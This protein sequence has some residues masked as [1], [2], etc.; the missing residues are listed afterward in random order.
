MLIDIGAGTTGM[1]VYEEG[2]LIGI[3]VFPVGAS[4]ITN[5]LAI[6]LKIPVAHAESIKLGAGYALQ[7]E[8]GAREFVEL[9]AFIPDAKGVLSRKLVAGVIEARLAEILEF[10]HTELKLLGKEGQLPGGAVV[11]GGGAKLPGITELMTREL[12]LSS[13]VGLPLSDG[14]RAEGREVEEALADPE[15]ST[16]IGLALWGFDK[17]RKE[18]KGILGTGSIRRFFKNLLP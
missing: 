3:S 7:S 1:I 12:R 17:E 15:F 9:A 4:N 6:A 13:Q 11:V 18:A 8:V 2:K 14:W 10:V 5:D 16:A